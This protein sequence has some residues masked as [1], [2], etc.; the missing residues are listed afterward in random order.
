LS[1]NN[2]TFDEFVC[3]YKEKGRFPLGISCTYG[4]TYNEKQLETKYM[5]YE[6]KLKANEKKKQEQ[7]EK[8]SK[9][10]IENDQKVDILWNN[11]KEAIYKRDKNECQ[12]YCCLSSEE[13]EVFEER[14]G[15]HWKNKLTPAHLFKVGSNP[16]IKYNAEYIVAVN[17]VSHSLLDSGKCPISGKMISP[18]EVENWWV[19]IAGKDKY[20]KLKEGLHG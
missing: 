11:M 5:K 13:K 7:N 2:L 20:Y 17:V 1:N 9:F 4:K 3:Y 6:N 8:L 16:H 18:E 14:V 10:S 19:R 15:I 12:L